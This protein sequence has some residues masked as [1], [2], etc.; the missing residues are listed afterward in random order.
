MYRI[1][2]FYFLFFLILSSFNLYSFQDT[3]SS[4]TI[5]VKTPENQNPFYKTDPNEQQLPTERT[6]SSFQDSA[7]AR[8]KRLNIPISTRL[9]FDLM[10][11]GLSLFTS[12]L[13]SNSDFAPGLRFIPESAY[14]PDGNQIVQQQQ[15]IMAALDVPFIRTYDPWTGVRV[16]FDAIGKLLGLVEDTSPEINFSVDFP[17]YVEVVIYSIQA[18]VIA[19]IFEGNLPPG[20]YTRTWNGR[21]NNGMKMPRGDY[22]AEVRIKG[23]RNVRK[24]IRID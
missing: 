7:Y 24:R 5:L 14:K 6:F 20:K 22:I 9:Q 15:N 19:K 21:D 8:A 2:K 11:F 10:N 16:P 4:N 17:T 12:S 23:D 13:P 1:L 18:T 3:N